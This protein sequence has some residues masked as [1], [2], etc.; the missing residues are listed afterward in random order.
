MVETPPQKLRIQ[1]IRLLYGAHYWIYLL[2]VDTH[3]VGHAGACRERVYCILAHKLRTS[4]LHNPKSLYD[5]IVSKIKKYAF[6]TPSDYF[7]ADVMDIRMAAH[8]LANT[9]SKVLRNAPKPKVRLSIFSI[10]QTEGIIPF[11]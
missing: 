10:S 7:V 8:D 6:T 4:V 3:E 11:S 2:Y 1:L 9:R 5:N